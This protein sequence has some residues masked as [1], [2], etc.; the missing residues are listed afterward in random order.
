MAE[1]QNSVV[2]RLK[3]PREHNG[4][5]G[6]IPSIPAPLTRLIGRASELQAVSDLLRRARLVTLTGAAGV[7]KTRTAIELARRQTRQ[8]AEGVWLVDLASVRADEDVAAETARALGIRGAA[9]DATTDAVRRYLA[10]LDVLLLLDNCEHVLDACA[11]LSATLLGACPKLRILATSREPLGITGEAVWRLESLRPEHAYRLFLE[12]ARERSPELVPDE[13]SEAAILNI[14]AKVDQLPL[15]IELAAARVS[16]MS[17][18]EIVTSLDA[19]LTELGRPRRPTPA[20]HRSVRAAVEWSYTL[21]D[22]IEQAA[23]RSLAVFV[24]GFDADAARAVAPGMSL[25]VLARLV[26]KSLI[27]VVPAGRH[28]TRYRLLDTIRAYAAEQLTSANEAAAAR[29]RHLRYFSTIGIPVEYEFMSTRV[30]S[31]LEPWAADYGNVRA[32]LE[33]AATAEPCA[34]M[35]LL[36]ETRDLFFILGQADGRRLAEMI[37]QRCPER[38]PHRVWVMIAASHFAFLLGDVAA[39]AG[40][41]T[42]AVDLSVELGE[43]TAESAAHSFLGIQQTFTGAPEKARGHLAAARAIQQE[44]GDLIGEGR[45]TAVLGLTYFMDGQLAR[46]RE[47]IET[48]LAMDLAAQ[49]RWSQGQ[50]NLYLGILAESSADVQAAS[51]Y[52]REAVECQRPYGDSTLL[53]VA[54]IGQA[55]VLTRRDPATALQIVA[56]A[57]AVRARNGGEFAPFFRAFAE[58]IRATAA[59]RV[60]TD[61]DRL[62]KSGSRLTVDDAIALAFGTTPTGASTSSARRSRTSPALGISTR[63]IDVVRLVAEGLSNK[64]IAGRLHLSVRTVESHVRHML[65]KTGLA[66]RTQ[67]ATWARERGE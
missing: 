59:E 11:E 37:L 9:L 31:L 15:G 5:Y 7:G 65:T 36:A 66:N 23:F 44:T 60:V 21:L 57:W 12:R 3:E 48:A 32:A 20:H 56:A 67:L 30:V 25:D 50:A 8:R 63:E 24:G 52:F 45:S 33:W 16:I 13:D 6:S 35:R 29:A 38:N 46:A 42:K 49:D 17:P 47:L 28:R 22:P 39:A 54:L 41:M 34:A 51:S 55:S 4:P 62:W 58:R 1:C 64:E 27:T 61:A 43:R 19:H 2:G 53:P 10:D 18:H 14:C 40:L 26:E